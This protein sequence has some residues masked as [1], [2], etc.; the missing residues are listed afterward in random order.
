MKK[1]LIVLITLLCISSLSCSENSYIVDDTPI[2]NE[3]SNMLIIDLKGA[4]RIPNIYTVK[5]GTILYELINLAGGLDK[6]ADVSNINLALILQENQMITIPFKKIESNNESSNGL[7][8]INTATL[9]ELCTLPGIGSAKATSIINYRNSNGYFISI[10]DIKK[11]SGISD[12][13]FE[14]IKDFICV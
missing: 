9:E 11:V 8:N 12:V 4:I 3:S 10:D 13:L 7:V 6:N 1:Y 5:E 14:K 2:G